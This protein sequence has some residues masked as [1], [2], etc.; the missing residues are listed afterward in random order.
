[1]V[2]K[3]VKLNH[4]TAPLSLPNFLR[5]KKM[6]LVQLCQR[7]EWG[8]Y[9]PNRWWERKLDGTR[10]KAEKENGRVSLINRRGNSYTEQFPELVA[11]LERYPTDFI[12]DGEICSENFTVLA[13]RTH[14]QDAFK[15][16]LLARLKPCDFFAFDILKLDG[17]ELTVLPLRERKE[18]L[19][20]LI[21][22]TYRKPL[23][24]ALTGSEHIKLL[25]PEPLP[26]LLKLVEAKEIEGV[27]GKNPNAPYEFK[28]TATWIKFRKQT[29]EDLPIIGYE[30]TD[31]LTRPFRS[32]IL[33][34]GSKEVQASSGLSDHDLKLLDEI[35]AGE[36]K[37]RIGTKWYFDN[38]PHLYAEVEFFGGSE[39]GYR[40]PRVKR[41]RLDK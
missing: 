21:E 38:P 10:C 31:K 11:D 22:S 26:D 14:L 40:F 7:G 37:H 19:K 36:P 3:S 8:S 30:D 9:P 6:E 12:L 41:L 15:I 33:K 35:F 27:V 32:L 13:G 16:S 2:D 24:E 17:R 20:S 29:A 34:R 18:M 4:K 25:M 28:R 5:W 23:Q 39:I 1:M